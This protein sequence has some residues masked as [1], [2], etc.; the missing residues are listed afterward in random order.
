MFPGIL[1]VLI[2]LL[3]GTLLVS[4]VKADPEVH[5][6]AVVN[7]LSWKTVIGEGASG[8]INVTVENQG[9]FNET[10]DVTVYANETQI[11][12]QTVEEM[13]NGTS[14]T[15]TFKWNTTGFEK[16]N[17]TISANATILPAES[18]TLDNVSED[19]T[20]EIS[21]FADVDGDGIVDGIDYQL[22]KMSIPSSPEMPRGDPNADIDGDGL[23]DGFD[24][25]RL[26]KNIAMH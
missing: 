12:L 4:T 5:D 10:F 11:G 9:T 23:V 24:F 8:N 25:Q 1:L 15:L 20:V 13:E 16:A 14:T 18:E 26:K 19:G 6:I 2:A 21:I 17:Y 7:V 22:V 3:L